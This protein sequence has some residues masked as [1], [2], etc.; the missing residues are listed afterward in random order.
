[1]RLPELKIKGGMSKRPLNAGV[2]E[3]VDH[4]RMTWVVRAGESGAGEYKMREEYG[5]EDTNRSGEGLR[6]LETWRICGRR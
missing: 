2:Q 1:M 6:G 5:R 3:R 4:R